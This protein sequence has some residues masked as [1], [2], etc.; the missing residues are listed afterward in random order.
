MLNSDQFKILA[1]LSEKYKLGL[2]VNG[3]KVHKNGTMLNPWQAEEQFDIWFPRARDE[4]ISNLF[5]KSFET[6]IS[7]EPA[8]GDIPA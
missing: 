1:H 3:N 7:N 5:I 2:E 4:F 6:E 8:P